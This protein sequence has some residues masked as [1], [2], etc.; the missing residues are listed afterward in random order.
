MQFKEL[1]YTS[2]ES[3]FEDFFSN[4][5]S[6]NRTSQF[7]VNWE[8]VYRNIKTH[9]DE[10]SL[11]NGL[12]NIH[13]LNERKNHLKQILEKYP[14][15][16]LILPLMIATRDNK[17]DLLVINEKDDITYL[18]IDFG[19]SDIEKIIKFCDET[20]IIEL[21]G[22]IKD[23]YSYLLGVEVGTDTNARKNR[24]GSMFEKM[25]LEELKAKGLDVRKADKKYQIG[26]RLKKPDLLLYKNQKEFAIIEVNFFNELG[27]KPLETIQSFI[28]LQK[29][30]K[31][32]GLKFILIT[33]GPAWKTGK[34]ER[35]KGFEQ[36]DYPLNLTL[37]VK[38]MPRWIN[39]Q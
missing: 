6:T 28:N 17:L 4:L 20:H 23:L 22:N 30:I 3:Y 7:F 10:I 39:G 31:A 11:I 27:S 2:E 16:R 24:S 29:D 5:L 21:L 37:A 36:L 26:G 13:D 33:D 25:V 38:L 32:L 8:K 34:S 19:N 18:D 1:G 35:I 15:T 12:I 14:K 9:I